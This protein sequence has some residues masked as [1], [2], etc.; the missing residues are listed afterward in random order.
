[1]TCD[2]LGAFN[3]E[4]M[5]KIVS[6]MGRRLLTYIKRFGMNVFWTMASCRIVGKMSSF[7]NSAT[8][9]TYLSSHLTL[10]PPGP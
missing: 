8:A 7:R 5:I 4:T 3:T 9:S 6:R 2:G 1:M 10:D